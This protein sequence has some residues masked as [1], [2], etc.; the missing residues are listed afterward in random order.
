M[1]RSKQHEEVQIIKD[2][3]FEITVTPS[4]R[5]RFRMI[6]E[7]NDTKLAHKGGGLSR[8]S[9]HEMFRECE[10]KEGLVLELMH[11]LGR[12]N[13]VRT[14]TEMNERIRLFSK[15][16]S[17]YSCRIAAGRLR[18]LRESRDQDALAPMEELVTT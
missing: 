4:L 16:T 9:Q 11:W 17:K 2:G 10:F 8:T 13:N 12:E 5:E 3:N 1:Q 6:K 15:L 18:V 7:R 14:D